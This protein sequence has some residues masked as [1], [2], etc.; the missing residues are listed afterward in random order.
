MRLIRLCGCYLPSLNQRVCTECSIRTEESHISGPCARMAANCASGCRVNSW[1]FACY[2][3]CYNACAWSQEDQMCGPELLSTSAVT[4]ASSMGITT[5]AP[6]TS[7]VGLRP[8]AEMICL[9]GCFS[10]FG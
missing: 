9:D 5:F 10:R 8:W 7:L 4:T 6:E 3:A 2:N 1:P